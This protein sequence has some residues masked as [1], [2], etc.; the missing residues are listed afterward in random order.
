MTHKPTSLT[1]LITF[2]SAFQIFSYRV[3]VFK[4]KKRKHI[5]T[6]FLPCPIFRNSYI[7]YPNYFLAISTS[8]L[9]HFDFLFHPEAFS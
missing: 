9:Q 6:E 2:W 4:E 3:L 8:A 7:A 5:I 1:S